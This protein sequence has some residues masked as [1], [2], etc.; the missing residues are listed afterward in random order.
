MKEARD[1][2]YVDESKR[3]KVAEHTSFSEGYTNRPATRRC[4]NQKKPIVVLTKRLLGMSIPKGT[5]STSFW[6]DMQLSPGWK[7]LKTSSSTKRVCSSLHVLGKPSSAKSDVFRH[8][9]V[10]ST[11]PCLSVRWSLILL[12]FHSISV[13]GCST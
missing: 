2:P 11:Y 6:K 12:N 1:W 3:W 8:A 4:I 13:P 10:S 9:R 7:L 5:L